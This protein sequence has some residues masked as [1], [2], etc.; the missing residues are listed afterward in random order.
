M[1]D[2]IPY[3]FGQLLGIAAV[4]FGFIS[5]QKK[6]GGGIIFWQMATAL[7]FSFHYLLIGALTGAAINALAAVKGVFYY[8]RDKKGSNSPVIPIIFSV[9]F[10][11]TTFLT[12]NGWYSIFI[13][14]GV[15][16]NALAFAFLPPQKVRYCMLVKAPITLLYNVFVF[17]V[18]G[19]VY[20][21]IVFISSVIGIIRFRNKDDA[22]TKKEVSA[23]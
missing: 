1:F 5:F 16:I 22:F 21:T 14:I 2:D 9:I 17:S 18:G 20:E 8:I 13:L 7:A 3:L 19:I 11:V 12:W 23:K 6:T 15:L 10:T 4:T